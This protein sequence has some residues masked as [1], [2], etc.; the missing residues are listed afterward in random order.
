[1]KKLLMLLV[2]TF[3]ISTIAFAHVIT[4]ITVTGLKNIDESSVEKLLKDFKDQELNDEILLEIDNLLYSQKWIDYYLVFEEYNDDDT[5]VLNFEIYDL[6]IIEEINFDNNKSLNDST[7]FENIKIAKDDYFSPGL[8][9]AN[10]LLIEEKYIAK[11]YKDVKVSS[12]FKTEDSNVYVTFDIEEGSCYRVTNIVINGAESLDSKSIINNFKSKTI[13]FFNSGN[14]NVNYL[15]QDL[16]TLVTYYTDRGFADIQVL[17]HEV[18]NLEAMPKYI[19]VEIVIN[20]NEGKRYILGDITFSGN[21]VF[22]DE[23]IQENILLEPG[24]I[25]NLSALKRQVELI[26]SL[27]YNTGYIQTQV[28]YQKNVVD[29]VVDYNFEIIESSQSFVEKII[30]NGL[31]KTKPYV[32]ER[33]LELKP[34]DIFTQRDLQKSGQNILNTGIITDIQSNLFKGKDENGVILELTLEEGNQVELQFGATFGGTVDSFPISGFL[35]LTDKNLFG[36]GIDLS[37][38]TNISPDTQSASLGINNEWT[39]DYRWSN[40]VSLSFERSL[41]SNILQQANGVKPSD[42]NNETNKNENIYP[43]GFDSY[44]QWA[45]SGFS[46]PNSRYLMDYEMY[47]LSLGFNS[48]YTFMFNAGRLFTGGSISSGISHAVYEDIYKPFDRQIQK[49]GE[50]WQFSNKI[51]LQLSWDGR[52]LIYNTSKGYLL[53]SSFTYAGGILGGISNYNKV[54]FS[55]AGFTTLFSHTAD[56]FVKKSLVLSL[57]SAT[58]FMLPQY[59][60]D[61][62]K[63][64][65]GW[66]PAAIGATTYEMLY[67]DGMTIGRGFTINE[68]LKH[69]SFLWNNQLELTYPLATSVLDGEAYVSAT[70]VTKDLKELNQFSNIRWYFS[71]GFGIKFKIPGF[72]LGLYLCKTAELVDG[73]FKFLPGSVFANPNK[74]ETSGMNIVLAIT[75]TLY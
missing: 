1:M 55:A 73:Q 28:N 41:K 61:I 24:T 59:W 22:S 38:N 18:N 13:S 21:K 31:G 25:D 70:G 75:T 46:Y 62:E 35:T 71:T 54:S 66:H 29:N 43:L 14:F 50:K 56:K 36:T 60:N 39:G 68:N 11:G 23:E 58:N 45:D 20:I 15:L 63:G 27:Y 2:L 51:S 3:C 47:N 6:P 57:T 40:G 72:P 8:L 30:I 19:P 52:D 48:G 65:L 16:Q 4:D 53:S 17:S 74:P 10:E 32:I 34:G 12:S 26:S 9:K 44:S 64:K 7:L 67:V 42:G 69:L 49:Y 37:I 5:C 33:E